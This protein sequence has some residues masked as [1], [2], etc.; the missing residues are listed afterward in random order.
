MKNQKYNLLIAMITIV[1]AI[2]IMP[3]VTYA[4]EE[5]VLEKTEA[6]NQVMVTQQETE[7]RE[8]PKETSPVIERFTIG[9]PILVTRV[10]DENWYEISFQEQ[11]L[12]IMKS[13]LQQ[14]IENAELEQEFQQMEEE[15]AM[16]ITAV[17]QYRQDRIRS[18]IWAGV[19]ILLVIGIF[20][21]GIVGSVKSKN[22]LKLDKLNKNDKRDSGSTNELEL[23]DLEQEELN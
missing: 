18:R 17:E 23:I 20:A 10:V 19:I 21:V 3:S 12:Y 14:T 11:T 5:D 8:Q 4:A 13:N 2:V 15:G 7:A 6:V 1:A 22:E 9:T 16:V